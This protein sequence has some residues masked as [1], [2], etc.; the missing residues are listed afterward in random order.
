MM[1]GYKQHIA[2]AR[3]PGHADPLVRVKTGGIVLRHGNGAAVRLVRNVRPVLS[4]NP[5]SPKFA[6]FAQFD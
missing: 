1:F 2:E 4:C 6:Q 3:V 5:N